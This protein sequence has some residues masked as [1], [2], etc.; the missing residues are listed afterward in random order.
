[1]LTANGILVVAS[2]YTWRPEYTPLENWIGGFQKVDFKYDHNKC[3]LFPE[4]KNFIK[5]KIM[6]KFQYKHK[7]DPTQGRREPL[8][9]GRPEGDSDARSPSFARVKGS[10]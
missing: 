5:M 9:R 10:P 6:D 7:L 2:P 4:I 3:K 1:M 8:H